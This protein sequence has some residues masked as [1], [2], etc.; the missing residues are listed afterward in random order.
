[1]LED[2]QSVEK[3]NALRLFLDAIDQVK[4]VNKFVF[5]LSKDGDS[6]SQWR[7]YCRV[8][9]G[10][11]VGFDRTK[12]ESLVRPKRWSVVECTYDPK[13]HQR[14]IRYL[15]E[16]TLRVTARRAG[17][18]RDMAWHFVRR[19]A[20][21]ALALKNPSFTDEREVRLVSPTISEQSPEV[22]YR[23]AKYTLRPY[24]ALRLAD[25][26]SAFP[27]ERIIVGPTPYPELSMQAA[28]ALLRKRNLTQAWVF[29][30][31]SSLRLW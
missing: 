17:K 7:A 20:D 6:L 4:T 18:E 24:F 25:E 16:Q 19:L 11:S 12:L 31:G 14:R 28:A 15:I 21:V 5:S 29:R 3:R 1:M 22:K 9:D 10:F 27:I 23:T 13:E 2:D 30:S 26:V 8:G